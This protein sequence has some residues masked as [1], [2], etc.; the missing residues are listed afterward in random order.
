MVKTVK[1]VYVEKMKKET[2]TQEKI[3]NLDYNDNDTAIVWM[4]FIVNIT[5]II[6]SGV[7]FGQLDKIYLKKQYIYITCIYPKRRA[8]TLRQRYRKLSWC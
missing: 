5:L 8:I 4:I 3:K 2:K 7:V 1:K 6:M